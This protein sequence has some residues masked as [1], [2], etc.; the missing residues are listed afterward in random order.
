MIDL[1]PRVVVAVG[2][3]STPPL[4]SASLSDSIAPPDTASLFVVAIAIDLRTGPLAAV[5]VVDPLLAVDLHTGPLATVAVDPLLAVDFRTGPLATVVDPLLAVDL[6]TGPSRTV[7]IDPLLA[8]VRLDHSE[9][10]L[11]PLPRWKWYT[12]PG[13]WAHDTSW[14]QWQLQVQT[15][16]SRS[17][18]QTLILSFYRR[19]HTSSKI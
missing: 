12:A 11:A 8:V 15:A 13:L 17:W 2:T 5:V 3:D 1:L 4:G 9:S 10:Q 19:R 6:R 14:K 16:T 7:A 18:L